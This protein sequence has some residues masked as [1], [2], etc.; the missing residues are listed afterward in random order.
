MII[1]NIGIHSLDDLAKRV[2]KA[3]EKWYGVELKPG[4]NYSREEKQ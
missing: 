2:H 3:R 4:G 1:D